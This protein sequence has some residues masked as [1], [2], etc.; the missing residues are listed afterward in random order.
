MNDII[1]SQTETHFDEIWW[2]G[3]KRYQWAG[4]SCCGN[5]RKGWIKPKDYQGRAKPKNS[6]KKTLRTHRQGI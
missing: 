6:K 3:S 1:I 5:Y 4:C 2:F